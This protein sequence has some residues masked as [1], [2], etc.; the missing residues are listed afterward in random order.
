VAF[1]APKKMRVSVVVLGKLI[2]PEKKMMQG[3]TIEELVNRRG[4]VKSILPVSLGEGG[5]LGKKIPPETM[6]P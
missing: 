4:K 2:Q 1:Q 6:S 5:T 3:P